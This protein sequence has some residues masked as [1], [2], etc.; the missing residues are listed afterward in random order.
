M[1]KQV[2]HFNNIN[3]SLRGMRGQG[4]ACNLNTIKGKRIEGKEIF[5]AD[6]TQ[7]KKKKVKKDKIL[8]TW[9]VRGMCLKYF[10]LLFFRNVALAAIDFKGREEKR[11]EG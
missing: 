4:R 11:G 5:K 6:C 2:L 9:L 7:M 10:I 3:R 1:K 8:N